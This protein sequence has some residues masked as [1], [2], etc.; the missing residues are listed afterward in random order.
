MTNTMLK[1]TFEDLAD[2]HVKPMP[3]GSVIRHVGVQN[4]RITLWFET[5]F[6]LMGREGS[7][8]TETRRFAVRGTGHP[9]P[10]GATYL[11]TVQ[12]TPFVWHVFERA[13]A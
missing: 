4:G 1:V 7:D 11:G 3:V 5:D 13:S 10:E 12:M 8:H 2:E 6:D 9:I